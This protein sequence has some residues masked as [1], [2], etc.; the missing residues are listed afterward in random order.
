MM[1]RCEQVHPVV[2][3]AECTS[4]F[5]HRHDLEHGNAQLGKRSKLASGGGEGALRGE[6]ADVKLVEDL[7]L[8]S[9]DAGP[10][11]IGPAE[12]RGIDHLGRSVRP[13]RLIPRGWVGNELT[14]MPTELVPVTCSGTGMWHRPGEITLALGLERNGSRRA[15]T[16]F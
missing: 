5:G 13:L 12:R 6:G 7:S 11:V 2:T 9:R 14:F 1:K 10:V 3:P 8:G 16:S 4:E 15:R